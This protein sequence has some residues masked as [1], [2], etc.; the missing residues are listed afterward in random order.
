MTGR[1]P[2]PEETP[3]TVA[4]LSDALAT[5]CYELSEQQRAYAM[6][7]PLTADEVKRAVAAIQRELG[8]WGSDRLHAQWARRVLA[9]T[10]GYVA[11]AVAAVGAPQ[12]TQEKDQ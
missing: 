10:E 9:N 4:D 3:R 5:V 12:T 1:P 11:A 7:T 2:R 6:F 8:E